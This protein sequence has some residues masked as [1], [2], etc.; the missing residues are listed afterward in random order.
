MIAT[1]KNQINSRGSGKNAKGGIRALE[2]Q[3]YEKKKLKKKKE[4]EAAQMAKLLG[5]AKDEAKIL[6]GVKRRRRRRRKPPKV[7]LCGR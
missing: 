7:T 3:A 6:A 1:I 2:S 4:K 5:I